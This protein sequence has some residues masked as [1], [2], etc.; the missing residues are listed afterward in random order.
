MLSGQLYVGEWEKVSKVISR[1]LDEIS[2]GQWV[3][4][5]PKQGGYGPNKTHTH[6]QQWT[7]FQICIIKGDSGYPDKK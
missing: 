1:F 7:W 2:G 3:V 6:T 4:Q 5:S